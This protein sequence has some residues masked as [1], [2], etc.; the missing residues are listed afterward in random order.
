MSAKSPSILKLRAE[1]PAH[2]R[3]GARLTI[4]D[5]VMSYLSVERAAVEQVIQNHLKEAL[6]ELRDQK[7]STLDR[8]SRTRGEICRIQVTIENQ[9]LAPIAGFSE[10]VREELLA[11]A[12]RTIF[13]AHFLPAMGEIIGAKPAE[14]RQ[15][16]RQL[17]FDYQL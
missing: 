7:I 17:A 10:R 11:E 3:I 4:D 2:L 16:G 8:S 9:L 12:L 15:I 5:P 14:A 13:A 1:L 6:L